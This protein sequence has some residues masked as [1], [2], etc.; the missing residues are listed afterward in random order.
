M[1]LL[2][3]L[4]FNRV[5]DAVVDLATIFKILLDSGGIR[6]LLFV[7]VFVLVLVL[8]C[9]NLLVE[10]VLIFFIT[11]LLSGHFSFLKANFGANL[12]QILVGLIQ[13]LHQS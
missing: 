6:F 4:L 10:L 8:L 2:F 1:R 7:T 5:S 3:N 11:L 13:N 12:L 9:L